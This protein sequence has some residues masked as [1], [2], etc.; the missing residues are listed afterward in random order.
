MTIISMLTDFG[1]GDGNVGVMKGVIWGIAPQALIADLSHEIE[2]QNVAQAAYLLDRHAP[3]FR[4]GSIHVVV[5]DPGVGTQRRPIAARLGPQRFVGPDNGVVTRLL[6]RAEAQGWE[7][8]L[9]H[10]DRLEYWL[11]EVSH[12]FH[13]RDI[14]SPVAAHLARG[15]ELPRLGTAIGDPVRIRVPGAAPQDGTIVGEVT[16]IDHFGNV[17]TSI[18]HE[19]LQGSRAAVVRVAG[20]EIPGLVRT[21]GRRAPGELVA[22][23]GSTGDLILAVVNGSAARELGV[24][25]GDPVQVVLEGGG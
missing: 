12:V 4:P 24:R 13:G 16:H 21:F 14:F 1:T 25:V 18:R 2:P 3:Y 6:E 20:R 5:V 19:H 17:A 15:V 10:L 22:L 9:V 7:I 11:P 23:Y 8:E